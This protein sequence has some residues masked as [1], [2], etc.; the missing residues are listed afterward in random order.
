M[1]PRAKKERK[2]NAAVG[3]HGM[4]PTLKNF[5]WR[6]SV[7]RRKKV[8]LVRNV[9]WGPRVAAW[10]YDVLDE[11]K[12]MVLLRPGVCL[13]KVGMY[14]LLEMGPSWWIVMY[15]YHRMWPKAFIKN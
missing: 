15:K 11:K 2:E 4:I 6:A 3:H 1:E 5:F 12:A 13:V 8:K 10:E 7:S 9:R 14:F